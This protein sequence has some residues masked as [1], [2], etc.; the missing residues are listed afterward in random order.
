MRR[1]KIRIDDDIDVTPCVCVRATPAMKSFYF[2]CS[3]FCEVRKKKKKTNE[4]L[5]RRT[6]SFRV[7]HC[8]NAKGTKCSHH[9]QRISCMC[10]CVCMNTDHYLDLHMSRIM[11]LTFWHIFLVLFN[12]Y[13]ARSARAIRIRWLACSVRCVVC[14]RACKW[15]SKQMALF[16]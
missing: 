8:S 1:R 7:A 5:S 9:H 4:N 16:C 3:F 11:L 15:R 14:Y 10:A 2:K 6:L 12:F 13:R